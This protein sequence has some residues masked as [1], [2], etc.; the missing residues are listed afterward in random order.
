MKTILYITRHGETEWNVEGI[1]QGHKDSP[2]TNLGKRQAKWLGTSLKE[3]EFDGIYSSP[4]PR[5]YLT[6]EIIRE[7]RKIEIFSC[8]SLKEIS[9][10]SWEGQK[11]SYIENV[12]PD[13]HKAFWN[14]PHLYQPTNSGESFSQ[15]QNRIIPTVLDII[16]KHRGCNVLIVT[17]AIALKVIMAYFR[18]ISLE[19]LWSPPLFQPTALNKI[20]IENTECNIEL[21]GDISHYQTVRNAVGAIAYQ[22]NKFIL[23]HKVLNTFG[24]PSGVWDFPKGGV[25]EGDLSLEDT[26]LRE[27]IEE[28]GTD[29]YVVKQ[30]L[31]EKITFNFNEDIRK[32]IGYTHQETTMFLVEFIGNQ[33]DLKPIDK[34]IDEIILVESEALLK[35]LS[36]EETVEYVRKH[37]HFLLSSHEN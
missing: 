33:N 2:L 3:I 11:R 24:D 10:G 19:K 28:T 9:L 26:V 37:C 4:S 8:D 29:K 36:H 20:V 22:G 17:H 23:V 25:E 6:A 16:A 27:L 31:P 21:H 34:E 14:T 32:R 30:E 1:L 35:R 12:F 5:T 7:E 15:L 18:G 13:E